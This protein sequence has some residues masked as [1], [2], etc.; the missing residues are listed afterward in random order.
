M[1]QL[2]EKRLLYW[3]MLTLSRKDDIIK[4]LHKIERKDPFINEMAGSIGQ[5]LDKTDGEIDDYKDQIDIEKATWALSNYE[6]ELGI[7]T[8]SS[9]SLEDRRSVIIAKLRGMGKIGAR[10]IKLVAESW[11]N[12][13]VDVRFIDGVIMIKFNSDVGIPVSI[14]DLKNEIQNIIPAH[15]P[16]NYE[17]K[18]LT[19]QEV[20]QL[21]IEQL[22]NTKLNIFG[23]KVAI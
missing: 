20:N 16:V 4:Q 13:E 23:G 14:N 19:I 2:T 11:V 12:G 18:Y 10:E 8:D 1:Y 17:F 6:R 3:E 9:K 5:Y 15:L 22:N 7:P 21:T